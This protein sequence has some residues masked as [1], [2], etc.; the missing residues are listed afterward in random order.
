MDIIIKKRDGRIKSF[1]K[2]RI[3]IA[4]ES[5]IEE[6]EIEND[7]IAVNVADMVEDYLIDNEISEIEVEEIQD[8]V[9]E[10]LKQE[11]EDIA[12]AYQ[13]Y[14]EEREVERIKNSRKEQFYTEVLQC[15]NIDNDNSNVDQNSFSGRKYRITDFEQKQYALRTLI[16]KR[17][18]EAFEQGL[19][20]Y[21]D[22][23]SYAV[24][25]HNCSFPNLD[26]GLKG[27]KT[28]NGDV[29]EANSYSTACQ[30]IAVIFQC[31]SQVQFGGIG[32]N[33]LDFTLAPYV[34][35]SFRKHFIKGMRYIEKYSKDKS[36]EIVFREI[37]DKLTSIDSD[38]YKKYIGAYN[39]AMEELE[40]EGSQSTQGLY[41]N[42]NTLES[43][44]GSQLP[45]TSINLGRDISVEGRL[46]SKWIFNSSIEGIGSQSRTPIFPISILQYK[47]GVNDKEQTP[48]YDLKKLA[49][50]SLSKRIYPNIVNGDYKG[51]I[52]IEGNPDTYMA[53]MG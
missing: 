49:I 27:F 33:H 6:L 8:L 28:R 11:N 12:K 29:R 19:I 21:H 53:T 52:E 42:L 2:D 45:F 17:G 7:D 23:S 24:G 46:V 51:N 44:A 3:E 39:Y 26:N 47:K 43:R 38:L 18:R 36:R 9:V 30:L 16:S 14:R 20:Y 41:H 32:S 13:R 10:F 34:K 1:L 48:N 25:E 50:K 35:K 31:Q 15:T 22:L 37:P 5:T 4:I 40:D